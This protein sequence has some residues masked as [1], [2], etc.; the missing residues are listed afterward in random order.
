MAELD[1]QE[2]GFEGR[3][4]LEFLKPCVLLRNLYCGSKIMGNGKWNP[5]SRWQAFYVA[6][7]DY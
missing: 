6:I 7:N 3:I 1:C 5:T 2:H 4:H